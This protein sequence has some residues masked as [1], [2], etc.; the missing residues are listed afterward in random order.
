M[1]RSGLVSSGVSIRPLI[2]MLRLYCVSGLRVGELLGFKR[3]VDFERNVIHIKR[4]IVKT[5]VQAVTDE[6]RR[7]RVRLSR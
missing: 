2:L 7:R 1:P 5:Y 6:K 4:S 3:E